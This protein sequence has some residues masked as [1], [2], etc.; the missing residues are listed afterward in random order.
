MFQATQRAKASGMDELSAIQH[1]IA[2]INKRYMETWRRRRR[3]RTGFKSVRT[4]V[5]SERRSPKA[6]K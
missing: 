3:T 1:A 4:H 2:E 6:G 5:R